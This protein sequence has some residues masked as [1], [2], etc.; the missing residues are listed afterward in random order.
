M[1]AEAVLDAFLYFTTCFDE[2]YIYVLMEARNPVT[3]AEPLYHYRVRGGTMSSAAKAAYQATGIRRAHYEIGELVVPA[4]P[5]GR[6]PSPGI[7]SSGLRFS[8]RA[9]YL[10][11][12]CSSRRRK[13]RRARRVQTTA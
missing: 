10:S 12:H 7:P 6:R 13:S 5:Q 4:G 2:I 11:F 1:N 9:W 3:I 8:I